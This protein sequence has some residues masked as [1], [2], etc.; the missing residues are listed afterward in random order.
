MF[1]I[2][3]VHNFPAG[4]FL[5]NYVGKCANPHGHNY[6]VEVAVSAPSLDDRGLLTDFAELKHQLRAICERLDHQMLNDIAPFDVR[7]PSAENIALYF[8]E[9]LSAALSPERGAAVSEVR[10]WETDTACA[11]FRP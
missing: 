1:E 9:E 7:N 10:V 11:V 8:Y 2:R 5:R 4:H 6:R 3:V